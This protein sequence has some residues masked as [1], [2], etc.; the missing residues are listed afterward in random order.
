MTETITKDVKWHPK[1]NK[2][3]QVPKEGL[4]FA[5][6][7]DDYHQLNQLVWCKDFMQDVIWSHLNSKKI[8]IYGFKYDPRVE[9][10]PSLKKVR[11]LISNFK[12]KELEINIFNK[13]LPLIHSVES[14]LRM[15]KTVVYKCKSPP[16]AYRKSGVWIIEG[17]KRWLKS[18]PMLSLYTLLIRTGLVHDPNDTLEQTVKKIEKGTTETYYD[19]NNRDKDI[20]RTSMKGIKRILR[21]K[22]SR[23]FSADIKK[24][25]IETYD[26]SGFSKELSIWTVHDRCGIVGFSDE[27]TKA[28]FPTW[29]VR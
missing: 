22:D 13:M 29:H 28:Y 9:K 6:L 10:P 21:E 27:K 26:Q 5:M 17:S 2:I 20:L 15:A 7:S 8:D 14:R 16:P 1:T 23:I 4:E 11:L 3:C 19:K 25:Y 18:P 24:N 12:D